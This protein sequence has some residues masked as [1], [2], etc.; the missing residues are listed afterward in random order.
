MHG[1]LNVLPPEEFTRDRHEMDNS[2]F[3]FYSWWSMPPIVGV[4]NASSIPHRASYGEIAVMFESKDGEVFWCHSGEVDN[5]RFLLEQ[6]KYS[7]EE[8]DGLLYEKLKFKRE[9]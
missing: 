1:P 6:M 2:V 7:D 8:I 3:N 9:Q 4:A 5:Y